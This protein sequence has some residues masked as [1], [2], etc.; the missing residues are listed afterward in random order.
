MC[1]L[2]ALHRTVPGAPLVVAANRDEYLERPAEGPAVR[3][4]DGGNRILAPVDLQAGGTWLGL[5]EAGVFAAVTN[6]PV[7]ELEPMRRS[8]GL[9]VSDALRAQSAAEAAESLSGLPRG[10]HNPFNCFVADSEQAFTCVYDESPRVRELEPGVHVIG[11]GEPNDRGHSKIGRILGR[12]E[13]AAR[14]PR[15]GVLD[16]L[17]EICREHEASEDPRG[18]TCVHLG[19]YG[20]G[21]RSSVLLMLADSE[22]A[23]ELR[24]VRRAAE[25]RHAG[26]GPASRFLS[27]EGAPC[28]APYLDFTSLLDELSR[29]ASQPSGQILARKAS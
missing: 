21:T 22:P 1:T 25:A 2:I 8:R 10:A 16:A 17:A 29:R 9:V 11:N 4:L 5:N 23:Q 28:V 20:Y 15:D 19:G 24:D 3:Q 6:R 27:A 7:P 14:V 18:D 13:Q 12:A 26:F